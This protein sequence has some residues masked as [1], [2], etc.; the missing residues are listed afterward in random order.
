MVI[1]DF[2]KLA[3]SKR[4]KTAYKKIQ[5]LAARNFFQEMGREDC[6]RPFFRAEL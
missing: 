5:V 3:G 1:E 4:R 6:L 2:L